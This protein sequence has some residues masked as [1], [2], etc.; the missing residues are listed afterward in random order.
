MDN[1]KIII[2]LLVV[3]IAVLLATILMY[4]PLMAKEDCTLKIADKSLNTGDSLVIVLKGDNGKPISD[5]DIKIKLTDDGGNSVDDK[6]IT[7]AKGKAKLKVPD[8][9]KYSVACYFEGNDKYSSK[10]L[11]GNIEVKKASTEV[12]SDEKTNDF[13]SVSGL[14][15]DGYSY[16]PEYGPDKDSLGVT[17]EYAIANNWNYIPQTIDGQ[18]AGVY[19]PYDSA[20]GC[21]HT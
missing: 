10:S 17:K 8:E 6:I 20:A 2:A 5:A 11:E 15:G 12:I 7:N 16:Y 18:D 14:S 9:G 19:V 13:D 21:Y 4:S 1:Q 3:I